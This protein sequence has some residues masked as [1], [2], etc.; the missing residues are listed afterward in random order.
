MRRPD[1]DGALDQA[2]PLATID[3]AVDVD[4]HEMVPFH[5]WPEHFGE[6]VA[7]R[8]APFATSPR[9]TDNGPNTIVRPDVLADDA[10]ITH[11]SVWHEKGASAPAAFDVARRAEVMDAM[12]VDRAIMF[13]SFGLIGIRFASSAA[14]G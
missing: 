3:H 6:E 13:P 7:E 2:R 8:M 4:T 5:L 10:P 1:M 14:L 11:E 9:F 12:G